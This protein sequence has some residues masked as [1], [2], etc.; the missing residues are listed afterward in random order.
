MPPFAIQNLNPNG[1]NPYLEIKYTNGK[2]VSLPRGLFEAFFGHAK[3]NPKKKILVFP[4]GDEILSKLPK[5]EGIMQISYFG[6]YEQKK[7]AMLLCGENRAFL[8]YPPPEMVVPC[9][10]GPVKTHRK[11]YLVSPEKKTAE[12]QNRFAVLAKKVNPNFNPYW[13]PSARKH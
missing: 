8:F 13:G 12:T 9:K 5:E 4:Q 7:V 2:G 1:Q 10:W 6:R 11:E 3:K